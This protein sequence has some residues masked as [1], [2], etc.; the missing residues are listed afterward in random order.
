[1]MMFFNNP[2]ERLRQASLNYVDLPG[3]L[4]KLQT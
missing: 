4:T 1:M 2:Y 3:T